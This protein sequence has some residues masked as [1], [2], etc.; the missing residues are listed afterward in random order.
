MYVDEVREYCLAKKYVTES[1]PFDEITLVFKVANKMFA[2]MGLES[3]PAA[4][5]LKCD[6]ESYRIERR[7]LSNY[8]W[9]PH[10]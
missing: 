10:E 6:P 8:T 7:F 4:V 2:L 9:L 5:N 1:F 3:T